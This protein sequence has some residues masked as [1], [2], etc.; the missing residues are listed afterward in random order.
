[1]RYTLIGVHHAYKEFDPWVHNSLDETFGPCT[2]LLAGAAGVALTDPNS[3]SM[4]ESLPGER[5]SAQGGV[6]VSPH[7]REDGNANT[8]ANVNSDGSSS[9]ADRR[10]TGCWSQ[11]GSGLAG[12]REGLGLLARQTGAV[13]RKHAALQVNQGQPITGTCYW[14]T[15]VAPAAGQLLQPAAASC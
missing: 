12:G 14:P 9:Q 11:R 8:G 10:P 3:L 6:G 4:D 1:M 2:R 5:A 13:L 15:A 7:N